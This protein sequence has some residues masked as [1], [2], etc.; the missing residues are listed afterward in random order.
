MATIE[1]RVATYRRELVL[2]NPQQPQAERDQQIAAFRQRLIAEDPGIAAINQR[3]ADA[4]RQQDQAAADRDAAL[5][6]QLQAAG[7]AELERERVRRRRT[8][9]TGGGTA[10]EFEAA[11]PDIRRQILTNHTEQQEAAAQAASFRRTRALF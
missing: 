9:L 3:A 10:E 8:W 2:A 11:W 6:E 5:A 4:K 1:D 7:A